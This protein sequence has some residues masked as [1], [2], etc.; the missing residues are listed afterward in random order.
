[1]VW[2]EPAPGGPGLPRAR[3]WPHSSHSSPAPALTCGH[4]R[5]MH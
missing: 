2:A 1:M 4:M 5:G 3:G